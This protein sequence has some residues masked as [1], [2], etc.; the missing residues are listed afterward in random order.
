MARQR[1][2]KEE[3]DR[4]EVE[5]EPVG[6][7]PDSEAEAKDDPENMGGMVL[8]LKRGWERVEFSRVA[9]VRR[10]SKNPER[11]FEEQLD[12]ELESAEAAAAAL[13]RYSGEELS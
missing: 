8:H 13:N 1:K 12:S 3:P 4:W 2:D 7:N 10:A 5:I 11:S 6:R 9:F